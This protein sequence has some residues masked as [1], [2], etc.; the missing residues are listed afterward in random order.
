MATLAVTGHVDML[1]LLKVCED[2]RNPDCTA[3]KRGPH[4]RRRIEV[5]DLNFVVSHIFTLRMNWP[6]GAKWVGEQQ[7]CQ[8]RNAHPQGRNCHRAIVIPLGAAQFRQPL[9]EVESLVRPGC[10]QR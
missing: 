2:T 1:Y 10:S 7:S 5:D 9:N 4:N 6:A 3:F 8:E